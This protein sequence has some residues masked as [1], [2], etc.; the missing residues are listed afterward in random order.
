VTTLGPG[1]RVLVTDENN[2]KFRLDFEDVKE[3]GFYIRNGY[4]AYTDENGTSFESI[5]YSMQNVEIYWRENLDICEFAF[6]AKPNPVQLFHNSQSV[7][8]DSLRIETL[9]E[10]D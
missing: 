6:K 1:I 7:S 2:R 8:I 10:D 4:A 3:V 5:D 9:R